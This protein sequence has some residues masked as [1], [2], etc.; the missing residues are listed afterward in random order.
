MLDTVHL[1]N[2]FSTID[3]LV[4]QLKYVQSEKAKIVA[5]EKIIWHRDR[6]NALDALI[7]AARN[8]ESA[9]VREA[10]ARALDKFT[11]KRV[12]NELMESFLKDNSPVVREAA[13]SSLEWIGGDPCIIDRL[14][15]SLLVDTRND[16]RQESARLLGLFNDYRAVQSLIQALVDTDLLVQEKAALSL[17]KIKSPLAIDP[18]IE[19]LVDKTFRPGVIKGLGM[20]GKPAL[21]PLLQITGNR[22]YL[23][24]SRAVRVL[25]EIGGP[26][27]AEKLSMLLNDRSKSVHGAAEIELVYTGKSTIPF[28]I[29]A[30]QKKKR[31]KSKRS[32]DFLIRVLGLLRELGPDDEQVRPLTSV[33]VALLNHHSKDLDKGTVS[34]TL[35]LLST[36]NITP[37]QIEEIRPLL[38]AILLTHCD[39]DLSMKINA[40]KILKAAK[41]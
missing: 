25:G 4:E 1:I 20:I 28:I 33:L 39:D 7:H 10:A 24:R 36:Q 22:D 11:G 14:I 17:G 37:E 21:K 2:L 34:Y 15:N 12:I 38:L 13:A 27:A 3:S 18:L 30:A 32:R 26:L 40:K 19:L 8:D 29:A 23:V 35:K 16:V 41:E 6:N 5:I 31:L 9:A